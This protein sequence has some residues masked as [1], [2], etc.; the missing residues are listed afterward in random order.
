MQTGNHHIHPLQSLLRQIHRPGYPLARGRS[1][2][3]RKVRP[4]ENITVRNMKFHGKPGATG[5]DGVHPLAFLYAVNC[6]VFGLDGQYSFAALIFRRYNTTY[7][8]ENCSLVV[9]KSIVSAG[10]RGYLT[11]QMFCNYGTVRNC[12]LAFGRHLNDFTC[13]SYMLVENCHSK[14]RKSTRL[15]S[16]H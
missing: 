14:D 1:L 13:S 2:T 3:Y 15:N 9:D 6:N 8:T 12:R 5:T 16:S 7:I 11:Q 10:G 4:I